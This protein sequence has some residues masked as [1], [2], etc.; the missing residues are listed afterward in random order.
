MAG[1]HLPLR[2]AD[3]AAVVALGS[4]IT[5]IRPLPR[6]NGWRSMLIWAES[7]AEIV[8]ARQ[9]PRGSAW[10]PKLIYPK[11][12]AVRTIRQVYLSGEMFCRCPHD[13]TVRS[14]SQ[15]TGWR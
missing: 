13:E 4:P 10:E 14:S 3:H 15:P 12:F 8:A 1:L 6:A 11:E 9:F 7:G 5:G 2:I